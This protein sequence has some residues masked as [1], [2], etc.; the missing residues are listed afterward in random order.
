MKNTPNYITNCITTAEKLFVEEIAQ[1]LANDNSYSAQLPRKWFGQ[2]N[3][4]TVWPGF[5]NKIDTEEKAYI[6]GLIYT[7][8]C[9]SKRDNDISITLKEEDSY[10]LTQIANIVFMPPIPKLCQSKG[11]NCFVLNIRNKRISKQLKDY[12][13]FCAKSLILRYPPNKTISNELFPHFFRGIMDGDGSVTGRFFSNPNIKDCRIEIVSGSPYFLPELKIKAEQIFKIPFNHRSRIVSETPITICKST[14]PFLPAPLY[15]I[16]IGKASDI[17]KCYEILY[18]D[19]TIYM[20]RK[21][22]R[23]EQFLATKYND[24]KPI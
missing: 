11:S 21:R 23:L 14:K 4:Y 12:G 19:A 15:S 6:L 2:H 7:D 16:E 20:K 3:K 5:F 22:I 17:R 8:G 24:F 13:V 9:N 1:K 10:I 18:K